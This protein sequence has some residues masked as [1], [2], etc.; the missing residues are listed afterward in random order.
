MDTP[1][2]KR[3]RLRRLLRSALEEFPEQEYA[4][5]IRSYIRELTHLMDRSYS[6]EP[7]ASDRARAEATSEATEEDVVTLVCKFED[8]LESILVGRL[9]RQRKR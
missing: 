6:T 1:T 8:Y 4:Q 3:E 5:N 9:A 7:G 2:P